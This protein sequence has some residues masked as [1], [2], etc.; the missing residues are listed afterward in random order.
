MVGNTLSIQLDNSGGRTNADQVGDC[1]LFTFTTVLVRLYILLTLQ[2]TAHFYNLKSAEKAHG[3]AKLREYMQAQVEAQAQGVSGGVCPCAVAAGGDGTVKWMISEMASIGCCHVPLGVIPFGTGNDMARV[4]GW[5]GGAPQPLLGGQL[6][7]LQKLLLRYAQAVPTEVDVWKVVVETH[8]A[9]EGGGEAQRS[10]GF[11]KVVDGKSTP[12]PG[13][14]TRLEELMINYFSVGA[15]A[16]IIYQFEKH[17][18]TSQL[19]NKMMMVVQTS[20]Q[21]VLFVT[22]CNFLL[23]IWPVLFV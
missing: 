16:Q 4:L 15:D 9:G 20:K 21:W 14:G 17:R 11:R 1:A 3:L 5:G 23:L 8:A 22:V 7:S 19:L 12:Q 10:G 2:V 18:Q 13:I 6:R